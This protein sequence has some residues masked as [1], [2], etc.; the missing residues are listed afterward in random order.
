MTAQHE[1]P[2]TVRVERVAWVDYDR[3]T[4]PDVVSLVAVEDLEAAVE[5]ATEEAALAGV[6]GWNE[7]LAPL[8][9][10]TA[11]G[12]SIDLPGGERITVEPTTRIELFLAVH[13]PSWQ[14]PPEDTAALCT[15]WNDRF[16]VQ[17]QETRCALGFPEP[18]DPF[19]PPEYWPEEARR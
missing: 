1:G 13:G 10:M 11:S 19:T 14:P 12:G 17:R 5:A 18:S 2:F 6:D 15:A 4:R 3:P 7:R 8:L 16:G 9:R